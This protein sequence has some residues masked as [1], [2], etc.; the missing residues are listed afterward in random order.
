MSEQPPSEMKCPRCGAN[1]VEKTP[2]RM[3]LTN[4]PQVPVIRWCACGYEAELG[5]RRIPMPEDDLLARWRGK[6]P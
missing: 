5:A 3:L 2:D 4:P 1:T 6:N